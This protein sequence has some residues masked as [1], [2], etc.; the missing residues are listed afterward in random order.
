M[1]REEIRRAVI[2]ALTRVAPEID[3]AAIDP[4]A[5]FRRAY[6]LDS[7]DYLNLIIALHKT[8]GI[9][10]PEQD[11]AHVATVNGAVE[12]LAARLDARHSAAGGDHAS[13]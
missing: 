2:A 11:Y 4:D 1:T 8:L 13:G 5:P 10:V 6:D 9:T 3:L 12:Y 7:M